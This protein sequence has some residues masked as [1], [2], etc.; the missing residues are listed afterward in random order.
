MHL[1]NKLSQTGVHLII[2]N[3]KLA[4]YNSLQK[5][6]LPSDVSPRTPATKRSYYV[7]KGGVICIC[8]LFP[9]S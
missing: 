8:S 9:S 7:I 2:F 1:L 3:V 4:L 6:V 5:I